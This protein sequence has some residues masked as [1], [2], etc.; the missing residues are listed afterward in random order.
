VTS[1]AVRITLY[2]GI[3]GFI[4]KS[5]AFMD[6]ARPEK[7]ESTGQ[8]PDLQKGENEENDSDGG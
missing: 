6:L 2:T 1:Q 7:F 4:V 3:S 8:R 5:L